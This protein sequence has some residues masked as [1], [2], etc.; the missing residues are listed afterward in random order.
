MVLA[1][2]LQRASGNIKVDIFESA[3]AFT[4]VGASVGVLKRPWKILKNLGLAGDIAKIANVP[5]DEDTLSKRFYRD[6]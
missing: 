1:I 4:E 3:K 5:E 2:G 6:P